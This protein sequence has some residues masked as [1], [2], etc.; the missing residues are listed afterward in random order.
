MSCLCYDAIND[1]IAVYGYCLKIKESFY[2]QLVT[3]LAALH[4]VGCPYEFRLTVGIKNDKVEIYHGKEVLA[5]TSP[6]FER[7]QISYTAL[8]ETASYVSRTSKS[9][10]E[11]V[12]YM[13]KSSDEPAYFTLA[14]KE[15]KLLVEYVTTDNIICY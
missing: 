13:L 9:V 3:E 6:T 1:G 11:W 10:T 8:Q 5:I 12:N 4:K 2:Q 7:Q 15:D 14:K